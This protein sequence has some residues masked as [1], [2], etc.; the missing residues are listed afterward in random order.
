[1]N[2]HNLPLHETKFT[3]DIVLTSEQVRALL[4]ATRNQPAYRDLH[5][6]ARIML[7][8]K[9]GPGELARLR[10][11]DFQFGLRVMRIKQPKAGVFWC[12][13]LDP[14][15]VARLQLRR[16]RAGYSE[17]VMGGFPERVMDHVAEQFCSIGKTLSFPEC[18]LQVL[19]RTALSGAIQ[20]LWGKAVADAP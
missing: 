5:D 11:T 13:I 10:W 7:R 2:K 16:D 15:T 9:I 18:G 14:N 1:M 8:S 20:H 4:D 12:T 6:A 19:R 17:F 3:G